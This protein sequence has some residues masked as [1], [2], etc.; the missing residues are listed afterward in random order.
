MKKNELEEYKEIIR[1]KIIELINKNLLDEAQIL[2]DEYCKIVNEDFEIYSIRGLLSLYKGDY[3]SA[4]KYF[5]EGLLKKPYDNDLLYNLANL[6]LIEEKWI[7]AYRTFDKLEKVCREDLKKDVSINLELLINRDNVKEYTKRKKVLVIAYFFP[8]LSGS[9]VQ[10]TLKFVKYLRQFDYEPIIVTAEDDNFYYRDND[11][12]DEIPEDLEIWRVN[13]KFELNSTFINKLI[14][15][16]QGVFKDLS[17]MQEYTAELMK[18]EKKL[19][20]LLFLPDS[21]IVFALNAISYIEEMIDKRRIDIIYSTSGP[22]SDH[23]LGFYIAQKFDRPWIV[24]FRDEWTNNPY[25]EYD[26]NSLIFRLHKKMEEE[27][28]KDSTHIVTTTPL[29]TENYIKLFNVPSSK[30]TT[31]TN[32][33]DEDDFAEIAA[34]NSE[35]LSD[36]FRIVHSGIFYMV[37]TPLPIFQ[38]LGKLVQED[39]IETDN[40]EFVVTGIENQLYW[41]DKARELKIEN[42]VKFVGYVSHKESLKIS[43]SSNLLLVVVGEKEENKT[44]YPGKIFEYLRLNKKILSLSPKDSLVEHLLKE[45]QTGQNIEFTDVDSITRFIKNEY[46]IWA[47]KRV[48]IHSVKNICKYSRIE[49]TKQLANIF[50]YVISNPDNTESC[51]RKKIDREKDSIFY[52]NLYESGGWEMTYFKHYTEIH[53]YETWKKA[54]EIIKRSRKKQKIIEVGCG[55]GQFANLLFDNGYIDYRGI[56]FSEEAIKIAKIRNDRYRNKF[57]V[58]DAFS[59]NIFSDDYNRVIIFEVLEHIEDDLELLNKVR[60]GT[61]ILFSVPN[62]DSPGHVRWFLSSAEVYERYMNFV[63]IEDIFTFEIGGVNRLFLVKGKKI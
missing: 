37:R 42:I 11:L 5:N 43:N 44:I 24:D 23:I 55:P 33:Y 10:R 58:E 53:Y 20:E 22:Y 49:L 48:N 25:F 54:L 31:I 63:E 8:P 61:D 2:V 29:A 7:S 26:K 17:L 35:E 39:M 6:Y 40:F 3:H 36:K 21:S 47:S 13:N 9:G 14:N 60:K 57:N 59:S 12:N 16:Y 51:E 52:D 30:I 46:D 41:E 34:V 50:D 27:F 4:E 32:G 38:A 18:N 56:D 19:N 1:T 45:Y 62:F 28:L 15:V